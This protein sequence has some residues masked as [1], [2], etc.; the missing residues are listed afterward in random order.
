MKL[1]RELIALILKEHEKLRRLYKA[2]TVLACI[3]VFVTTYVLMLP[4]ITL[5][6]KAAS[7][8]TGLRLDPSQSSVIEMAEDTSLEDANQELGTA[9]PGDQE[10]FAGGEDGT[11][12]NESEIAEDESGDEDSGSGAGDMSGGSS[13]ESSGSD[14]DE[15]YVEEDTSSGSGSD[16]A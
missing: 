7:Q 2:A 8:Q 15:D 5:D 11:D 3:V 12:G 9:V 4:A 13:V 14:A 1:L 6:K 10:E 16:D